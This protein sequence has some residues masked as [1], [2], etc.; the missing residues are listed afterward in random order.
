[1]R[2][3]TA[4]L[5]VAAER[6]RGD[7]AN[8]EQFLAG[9]HEAQLSPGH[10][11]DSGGIFAQPSRFFAQR[12]VLRAH[13]GKVEC[14]LIVLFARAHRGDKTLIANQG[15]DDEY[16]DDEEEKAGKNTPSVALRPLHRLG[17]DL[18]RSHGL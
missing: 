8:D 6:R 14:Q 3:R 9:A 12:R 16:A 11:L 10:L 2:A 1:M 7:V 4:Y 17:F 13:P 18:P 15:V 5:L